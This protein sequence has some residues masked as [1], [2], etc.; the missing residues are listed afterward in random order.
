MKTKPLF[1]IS[2]L[3]LCVCGCATLTKA[4]VQIEKNE[5]DKFSGNRIVETK[6]NQ[7]CY[8]NSNLGTRY[9][10]LFL[11]LRKVD[12]I[13]SMPVNIGL[14]EI[15]KYVA[16]SGITFLLDNGESVRL[17]SSYTGIGSERDPLGGD[18]HYFNT[19]LMLTDSDVEKLSSHKITDVRIRYL[20]GS[21]DMSVGEKRQ[22]MLITMFKAIENAN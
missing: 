4:N 20:G 19:T 6:T 18:T 15:E 16:G 21:T 1:V 14:S 5:T 8:G 3:L 10:T 22:D 9:S 13:Y 11:C 12:N 17:N 2:S 7:L